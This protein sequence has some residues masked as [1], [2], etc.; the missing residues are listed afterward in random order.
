MK[1]GNGSFEKREQKVTNKK[2][3]PTLSARHASARRRHRVCHVVSPCTTRSWLCRAVP[4]SSTVE[5]PPRGHDPGRTSLPSGRGCVPCRMPLPWRRA[6][7]PG[8]A[9]KQP[10]PRGR[11]P[12]RASPP[13][14]AAAE[15]LASR[16]CCEDEPPDVCRCAPLPSQAPPT[17]L[18]LRSMASL[19]RGL[20]LARSNACAIAAPC[21]HEESEWEDGIREESEAG[22]EEARGRREQRRHH[23]RKGGWRSDRVEES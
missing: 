9:N 5:P 19:P 17:Q 21:V 15:P 22:R 10:L 2:A 12:G 14:Q 6:P 8:H 16:R 3:K 4:T 11:N 7:V 13:R 20:G 18:P 23:W 1:A